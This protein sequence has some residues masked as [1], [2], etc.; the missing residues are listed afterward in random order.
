MK[1][2]VVF[3]MLYVIVFLFFLLGYFINKKRGT[4]GLNKAYHYIVFKNGFKMNE[5]RVL[6]LSKILAFSNSLILSLVLTLMWFLDISIIWM[7]IISFIIF[8]VSLFITYNLIGYILKRKG[9]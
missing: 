9:W 4:L 1:Y 5:K 6:L 3:I 7:M 8:I 2:I